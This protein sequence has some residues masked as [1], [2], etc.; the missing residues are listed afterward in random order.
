[1]PLLTPIEAALFLGLKVETIEYLTK[2]CP[3]TGETRK[4]K[5]VKAGVGL[6]FD[7]DE[8]S[9]YDEYLTEPRRCRRHR[10]P[11]GRRPWGRGGRAP[12]WSSRPRPGP[13][14]APSR[15]RFRL[16]R[17]QEGARGLFI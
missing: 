11:P 17:G 13:A 9:S 5:S 15:R 3:K 14:A 4:I 1:M 10:S 2:N 12:E 8:L 16:R 7:Q 6:M